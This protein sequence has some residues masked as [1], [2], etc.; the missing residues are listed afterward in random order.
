LVI[1]D[2]SGRF[3]TSRY[4]VPTSDLVALLVLEHQTRMT[5]LMIRIG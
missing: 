1:T 5:N 4:L 3:D 2:L